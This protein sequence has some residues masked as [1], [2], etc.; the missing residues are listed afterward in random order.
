MPNILCSLNQAASLA[1]NLALSRD[2]RSVQFALGDEL[3]LQ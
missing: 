1:R 2:L 3:R